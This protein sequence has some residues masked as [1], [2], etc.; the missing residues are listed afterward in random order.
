MAAQK[1][2]SLRYLWL[3]L[4]SPAHP[5]SDMVMPLHGDK[6]IKEPRK[7]PHYWHISRNFKRLMQ[8]AP[9]LTHCL[10]TGAGGGGKGEEGWRYG[11][12]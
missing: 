4:V 1:Q 3:W 11:G 8:N 6:S 9:A 2:D 10:L 12:V 5:Y 7:Q